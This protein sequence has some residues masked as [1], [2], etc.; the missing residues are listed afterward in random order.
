[1]P[2]GFIPGP[3]THAVLRGDLSSAPK[4]SGNGAAVILGF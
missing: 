4:G 2:N 3:A 1:M